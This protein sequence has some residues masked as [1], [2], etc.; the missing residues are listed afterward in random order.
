MKDNKDNGRHLALKYV[1]ILALGDYLLI[2]FLH[3]GSG[4][5][6]RCS[7]Q[8]MSADKCPSM[9][10]AKYLAGKSISR[11]HLI[12]RR[13]DCAQWQPRGAA[14]LNKDEKLDLLTMSLVGVNKGFWYHLGFLERNVSSITSFCSRREPARLPRIHSRGKT[15][16]GLE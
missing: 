9:S 4:K 2:M 11:V 5:S 15:S 6:V 8:I 7:E 13:S 16:T 1:Q 10:F 14:G 3:L 12:L